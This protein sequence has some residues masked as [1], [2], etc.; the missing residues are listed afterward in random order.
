MGTG[1]L[2][3]GCDSGVEAAQPIWGRRGN[4]ADSAEARLMLDRFASAGGT[5]IDTADCYQAG[6]SERIVGDFLAADRDHFVLATKFGLG[7][8]AKPH[9]SSTGNSRKTMIS[10]LEGSLRRLETDYID[11]YWAHFSDQITPIEEI[12]TAFED[13]SRAGKIRYA[14]LSNF[15][16]WR[17]S[18]AATLADLR[19]WSSLIG[20]QGEY[21]LL[22]R[23]ADRE[24]LPM[25]EH[26]GLGMAVWSPLGGGLLSGSYR[27][28]ADG[29]VSDRREVSMRDTDQATQTVTVVRA[30]AEETGLPPAQVAMA[31]MRARAAQARTAF[32]PIIG[33]RSLVQLNGY[34]ETLHLMP[35]DEQFARLDLVST[36]PLGSPHEVSSMV[37]DAM[38]GGTTGQFIIP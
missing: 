24:L 27:R 5:F 7:V 21:S 38:L 17:I 20:A 28:T 9:V 10:A 30:I 37:R 36:V 32:V 11:L 14:G 23:T 8:S 16:A 33:P 1:L 3:Q 22:E 2:G 31:W 6:E 15:A 18:Q 13:L 26:L 19:G 34:L 12:V 35:T 25:A 4:G 29:W